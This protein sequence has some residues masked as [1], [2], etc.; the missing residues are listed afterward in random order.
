MTDIVIRRASAADEPDLRRA[1]VELQEHERRLHATRLPGEQI[2]EAYVA[3]LQRQAAEKSGTMMVAECDGSFAGFVVGWIAERD[4][5]AVT[6]DANRFGYLSD[7]CVM[8]AYRGR[9]IAHQL[10]AAIEQHL[11]RAGITRLYLW[12][13]AANGS[14][15]A[16]YERAGFTPYEIIYEKRV[17]KEAGT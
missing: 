7:I 6:A 1:V 10:I 9:R 8:P 15:R 11:A 17:D 13:L 16:S 14:A 4:H 3:W 2:A 12:T 5:I